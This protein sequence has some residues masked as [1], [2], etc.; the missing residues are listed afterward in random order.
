MSD[1]KK[2]E[3][4]EQTVDDAQVVNDNTT[5]VDAGTKGDEQ[6]DAGAAMQARCAAIMGCEEAKGRET[7][8]SHL[9]FK[10]NMSVDD[11]K[12]TLAAAPKQAPAYGKSPLDVAMARTGG[13]PE[14]ANNGG[15]EEERASSDN[16]GLLSAYASATGNKAVLRAVK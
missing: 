15:D 8:A 12:A 10:T 13:G 1:M 5:A 7:L 3:V 4:V 16:G 9:A 11:A 6:V 2:T 14:V